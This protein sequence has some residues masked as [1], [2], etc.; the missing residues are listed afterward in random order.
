[1][2]DI[3]LL[4]ND[5]S[6]YDYPQYANYAEL[7]RHQAAKSGTLKYLKLNAAYGGHIKAAIYADSG[8][9]PGARLAAPAEQ[10]VTAGYQ[11]ISIPDL[12]IVA[13]NY[14]WIGHIID[15]YMIVNGKSGSGTSLYKSQSYSGFS[16]PDPAPSGFSSESATW[17]LVG[18]GEESAGG[19]IVPLLMNQYR[20]RWR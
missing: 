11:N 6:G 4:G 12:V 8:G 3:K 15:D 14:Y 20:Q 5:F 2:A 7:E 17:D 18:W 10:Y 1:M 19:S 13:G 9:S 16:W